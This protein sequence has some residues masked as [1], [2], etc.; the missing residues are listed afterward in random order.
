[1]QQIMAQQQRVKDEREREIAEQR[2]RLEERTQSLEAQ[3]RTGELADARAL[4]AEAAAGEQ[5]QQIGSLADAFENEPASATDAGEQPLHKLM[6]QSAALA[7]AQGAL[8]AWNQCDLQTMNLAGMSELENLVFDTEGPRGSGRLVT[9]DAST[10]RKSSVPGNIAVNPKILQLG[11]QHAELDRQ[12]EL[13]EAGRKAI[14]LDPEKF[15][16]QALAD[17]LAKEGTIQGQRDMTVFRV[18]EEAAKMADIPRF[19]VP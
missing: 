17:L 3:Q 6:I 7:Q 4:V 9:V 13:L 12:L 1:M 8:Q 16:P 14:L 5:R 11:K 19:A 2:R 10:G 18:R 15:P